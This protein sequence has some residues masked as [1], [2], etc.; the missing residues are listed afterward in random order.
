[1]ANRV[2]VEISAN[3][4]GYVQGVDKAT[5]SAA[6][7]ETE[8]RK[9]SESQ[10][11]LNK[12]LKSAQKL[13]GNLAAGYAKLDSAAKNS[14]FGKEMARQLEEAKQ[15]AA[16]Y[17]DMQMDLRQ[18]MRNMASD[19]RALDTLAEGMGFVG[20]A[21][22]ATMGIIS[23]FTGKE[24][25]AKRA[26]VAFTTAQAALGTVTKAANILQK[27]S[28][29]MLAVKALQSKAAAAATNLEAAATGKATIAQRL[30]NAVAK[31]NPYVLLLGGI[32][33]V[34]AAI[35]AFTLATSKAETAQER[36]SKTMH[37]ASLK[38]QKDA[39]N[40]VTKLNLLYN[41]TQDVTLSID[42]RKDAAEKLQK[43]YP[44]YFSN[45]STEEIMLGKAS[46][47]YQQLK[48]DIISVAKAKAY[49][50][51]ITELENKNIDLE[52]K[53]AEQEAELARS[54]SI[55]E[56][57]RN[58][59]VIAGATGYAGALAGDMGNI[60][61]QENAIAETEKEITENKQQQLALANKYNETLDAQGR[62]EQNNLKEDKKDKKTGGSSSS[63][64]DIKNVEKE[65]KTYKDAV[66]EYDRL[67]SEKK[68]L[69]EMLDEGRI[70]SKFVDD[71]SKDIDALELKMEK[72]STDWHIN[73]KVEIQA[74]PK[75][76]L[77]S[78]QNAIN[79]ALSPKKEKSSTYNF[80]YLPEEFNKSANEV[81]AGM[82]RIEKAKETLNNTLK[83]SN[84]APQDIEA[85]KQGL[86]M[87]NVE[88][89]KLS[90]Q[91]NA[92]Q[93]LSDEAQKVI[94]KNKEISDTFTQI[95]T[96][97]NAASQLFSAFGN[98]T[99][100][101]AIKSA[102]IVAQAVATIALSYANAMNSASKN[103]VTW[104][105]FGL[106]GLGTMINMIAQ[107]KSATAGSYAEGGI[108]GGS[109]YYGDRLTARVNSGEMILN[110]QQQRNLFDLLDQGS[111]SKDNTT[112]VQVS[113]V[114]RGSDLILVQKNTNKIKGRAGNSITF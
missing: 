35:I 14:A 27:Q 49:S 34:T 109:S 81:I 61:A 47:A 75:S 101:S 12:E 66:I 70:D 3:T 62:I 45:M 17:L 88:Y 63:N 74:P 60:Q 52:A 85:A 84:A 92:Y 2:S 26:V 38:G 46:K 112:N 100:D 91:A 23:Q 15:K 114:I 55:N 73:P 4:K 40:E 72:I 87:L 68:K 79:E 18:E 42:Q 28:N 36:L 78:I 9:I 108:V 50:D 29:I 5:Q 58:G 51:K 71:F 56:R 77:E 80:D 10:I 106:T 111:L 48:N 89:E 82:Q 83:D 7:Y 94:D 95:G 57:N 64:K 22:A 113:G 16:N 31:A 43:Q 93:T 25:D 110:K 11:N 86:E 13:A 32:A 33:A 103:W 20:D 102:G 105:A 59:A 54:R 53:K 76:N 21:T 104:L 67:A 1:M 97:L 19:T 24:E 65:L 39:Q 44:A 98:V 96:A 90:E 30:F 41:A 6:A 69:T 99:D 8:T 107:I 37:E